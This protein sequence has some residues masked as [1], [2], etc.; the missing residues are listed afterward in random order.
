[1]KW[2][3]PILCGRTVADP[4]VLDKHD[5][6]GVKDE[7]F[8]DA[9]VIERWDTRAY[10]GVTEQ[11]NN[12]EPDDCLQNHL[13]IMMFSQRLLG[14]CDDEGIR[15]F[16]YLPIHVYRFDA[17]PINGFS[18]A[19]IVEWRAALVR[20]LSDFN[21]YPQ[22]YFLPDRRGKIDGIRKPVLDGGTLN[23][24]DVFRLTEYW[25]C[26]FVS[27]RLQ[28]VFDDLKCT[29]IKFMEVRVID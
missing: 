18:I 10:F 27:E 9:R 13:N 28:R 16:Q 4:L 17:T 7:A 12:G 25:P 19:H 29:G 24:T 15:G 26:T 2:Y 6:F 1:M 22:D 20:E 14:A 23:D 3:I 8:D 11:D 5:F 21:V